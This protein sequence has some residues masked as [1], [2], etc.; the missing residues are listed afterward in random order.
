MRS[1]YQSRMTKFVWAGAAYSG[2]AIWTINTYNLGPIG[3][4]IFIS[5]A[6]LGLALAIAADAIFDSLKESLEDRNHE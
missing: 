3:W 5:T 6:F 1:A 2:A 4:L